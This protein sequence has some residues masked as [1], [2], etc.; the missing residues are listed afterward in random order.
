MI[1]CDNSLSSYCKIGKQDLIKYEI[2]TVFLLFTIINPFQFA[3]ALENTDSERH[4]V[5]K[6]K[7]NFKRGKG[8]TQVT[9]MQKHSLK[10]SAKGA[11]VKPSIIIVEYFLF[12]KI[13]TLQK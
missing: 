7:Y 8:N 12:N 1:D 11:V 9:N 5:T 6:G 3:N 4:S 2:V 10:C 13:Y